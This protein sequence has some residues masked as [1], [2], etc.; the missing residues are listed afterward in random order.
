MSRPRFYAPEAQPGAAVALP[1]E[2]AHHLR[3]VLR[4]AAGAEVAVFDGRGREWEARVIGADRRDGIT[5][6]LSREIQPVAEPAVRVTLG[7]G[8]LKGDQMDAVV[9][10]ATMLGVAAVAP[11][12]SAHVSV[13]SRAWKGEAA[14][15]RWQRV[16]IASAKQCR[17]AVVPG[18]APVTSFESLVRGAAFDV[19]LICVEP[20]SS[21]DTGAF[22]LP[23]RPATAIVLVGPEGGWTAEELMIARQSSATCVRCGPRTL[24]AET[25]PTVVLSALWTFWGW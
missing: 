16:A 11:F 13:P 5:V 15:A 14:R 3:H 10:D 19:R 9:R 24:R 8:M 17:R 20:S 23:P 6:E 2:E 22:C 1:V 7:I 12:V 21:D 4:L 18:I 25:A